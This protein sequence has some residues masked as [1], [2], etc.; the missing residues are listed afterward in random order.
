MSNDEYFPLFANLLPFKFT[1]GKLK[2]GG[3][4]SMQ[5]N[6]KPEDKMHYFF[7]SENA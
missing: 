1:R 2:Q 5:Q 6:F 7:G 3:R 4:W